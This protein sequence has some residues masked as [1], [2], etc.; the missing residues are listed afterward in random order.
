MAAPYKVSSG[1]RPPSLRKP[2]VAAERLTPLAFPCRSDGLRSTLTDVP[3]RLDRLPWSGFHRLVV[4]ALGITWILDGLEVTLA[5]SVAAALQTS[6]RLHLTRR[7]GRPDRQRLPDR[8]GAGLAVLRP[9]HRP[10]RP[11]EAVQRDPRRL[12]R[13]DGG[14]R[15]LVELREL[16]VLP[17]PHRRG[18]RRRVFGDQLGDPGADPRAPARPHRPRDQRQLLGRRRGA[19]RWSRCRCS[20]PS[21]SRPDLGWRIAFGSGAVLGLFILY[22]RRFLPESPRWLMIHGQEGEAR[23]V[24]D[25]IEARVMASGHACCRPSRRPCRSATRTG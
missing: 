25:E 11:Q 17:L 20:I 8:R 24:I 23:K 22:L 12:S 2:A 5:G 19:A 1:G 6:P 21:C 16:P 3:A 7:A 13:R 10:A 18:H 9:S 15:L 4:A 14:D